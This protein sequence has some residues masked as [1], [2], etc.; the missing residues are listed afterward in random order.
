MIRAVYA[1]D[2]TAAKDFIAEH[3]PAL[4]VSG[5]ETWGSVLEVRDGDALAGLAIYAW[6]DHQSMEVHVLAAPRFRGRWTRGLIADLH[7]WAR[8]MGAV[9]VVTKPTTP[10]IA[11][12][13]RRLG[14]S[15]T[16]G[17]FARDLYCFGKRT[18]TRRHVAAPAGDSWR[19]IVS[20]E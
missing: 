4:D 12:A 16:N 2:L 6:S 18:G 9:R 8:L 19:P 15:E 20:K 10:K 17:V 5:L 3:A 11:D 1:Y 14:W 7:A 13:L